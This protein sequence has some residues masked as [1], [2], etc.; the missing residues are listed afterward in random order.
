MI[1][2]K[3]NKFDKLF[4]QCFLSTIEKRICGLQSYELFETVITKQ[5]D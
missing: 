3:V 4:I 2:N 5:G 1:L